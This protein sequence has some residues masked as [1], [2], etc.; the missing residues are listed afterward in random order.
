MFTDYVKIHASAG[1]GG[2][3]AISFWREKYVANGG[4]DGGDGGKGGNVIFKVDKD[5]NTLIEFRFKKKFKAKNGDNGAGAR[6]TGKSAEDLYIPVPIGTIIRDANT[7]KI[8]ADLSNPEQ[9]AVI[10]KGG[11]GGLGNV[12]FTTSTRQAPHFAIGGEPGEE[13]EL[14]LELKI[15][16]DVGLLGFPNAGKSTFLSVTTAARPKIANYQFTTLEPNLGVVKI[17]DGESFVIADIPGLIEGASEGV[18]LGIRFLRHVERTRL[19]LH[20]IDIS[21]SEERSPRVAYDTIINEL[22]KYSEKLYSKEQILVGTKIDSQKEEDVEELKAIAKEYN[23]K[24][25]LIS[26]A[27]GEGVQELLKY[28]LNRL[29]EIPKTELVEIEEEAEVK[30]YKLEE[31]VVEVFKEDGVF[32]VQSKEVDRIL[33]RV[34]I[35]DSESLYYLH[36]KMK[37]LG[38]DRELKKVGVK[39]GD[40]VKIGGFEM[41]WED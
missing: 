23:L 36:K 17:N 5:Y 14:I 12:H 32:L 9:Q 40:I 3:G 7:N 35:D 6:C 10:L 8:L 38:V 25:F 22:K 33:R 39:E 2:D 29:K 24:L 1:K 26:S 34:N 19:L 20:L 16:A 31:D 28:I 11:R 15:L 37:E 4:P 27:T 41:E 13:K 30:E 21:G 18:G